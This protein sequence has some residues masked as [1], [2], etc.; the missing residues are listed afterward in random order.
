MTTMTEPTTHTLRVDGA[1]LTY[2]VRQ[3]DAPAPPLMLI[4]SPMGA[5]GFGTLASH[6]ADRTVVT[7][8]PRGVERSTKDDPA[9]ESTPEQ[10]AEDI[11]RIIA[12]LGGGPVDLFASSGGAVNAL[13]LVAK[14]PADVRTLVAHE[15]PL[16]AVVPDREGALA[17]CEAVARSYQERG[18][19]A[20][21]AHFITI[22]SHHGPMTTGFAAQ[23]GPDPA[24][25]GM[26][27]DDDGT[28][29]DALLFQNLITCT[30]FEP[31]FEALKA[32]S[33]RIV[34]AAGVESAG[35]LAC[36]GAE[37]AAQRLGVTVEPFPSDHGGFLGGEYGQ[38]GDPDA[39]AAKLREVLAA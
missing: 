21:M 28:R 6:F 11:H 13:A 17:V 29:T 8:D 16:A 12:E 35:Q 37:A 24:M 2:D 39:F 25:F 22:V 38:A 30:H 33:T 36:R 19:G 1:T 31:D 4:G 34:M 3:G 5:G 26:P 18:F 14:H 15:P 27:A 23:P 20:G 32:A 10:H 9:T 7:Y